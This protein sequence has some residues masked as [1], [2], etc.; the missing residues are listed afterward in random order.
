MPVGCGL[1]MPTQRTECASRHEQQ[2]PVSQHGPCCEITARVFAHHILDHSSNIKCNES[3]SGPW[4]LAEP[5]AGI[6]VYGHDMR[7]SH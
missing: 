3:E 1:L 4:G 6:C 7:S 5:Q 2:L